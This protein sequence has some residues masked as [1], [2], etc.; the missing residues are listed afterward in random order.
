MNLKDILAISGYGGLYKTIAKTRG[1]MIVESL[2]DGKRMPA[3]A[4]AKISALEDIAIYT[5]AE[6]VPLKQVLQAI[7]T[8]ENGGKAIDPKST[9]DALKAYFEEVLPDYDKSRVYTSDMKR[10]FTWYNL[11]LE[12]GFIEAEEEVKAEVSAEESAD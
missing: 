11:L 12:K 8:K 2:I 5:S 6:E 9:G 4:T 7:Y 1:G 10:L 3:N